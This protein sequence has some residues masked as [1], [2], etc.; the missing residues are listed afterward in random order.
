MTGGRKERDLHKMREDIV[1]YNGK[2]YIG[3]ERF[4]A[5]RD[6]IDELNDCHRILSEWTPG[7]DDCQQ[8]LSVYDR[9][10]GVCRRFEDADIPKFS[11]TQVRMWKLFDM[12]RT[13]PECEEEKRWYMLQEIRLTLDILKEELEYCR[14]RGPLS[15]SVLRAYHV[16]RPEVIDVDMGRRYRPSLSL[17]MT[18]WRTDRLIRKGRI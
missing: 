18:L 14:Y 12:A 2:R 15:R 5:V 3:D 8:V 11:D 16:I 9:I 13:I 4:T 10:P 17:R 6:A 1:I 7:S